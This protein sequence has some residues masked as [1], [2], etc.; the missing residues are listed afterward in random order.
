MDDAQGDLEEAITTEPTLAE[1]EQSLGFLLLRKQNLDDAETHFQQAVKLDPKDALNFYGQGLVV[2]GQSGDYGSACC[3]HCRAGKGGRAEP[4]FAEIWYNLALIYSQKDETL[5]KALAAAQHAASIAPGEFQLPVAAGVHSKRNGASGRSAQRRRPWSRDR[6]TDQGTARK[7]AEIVAKNFESHSLRLRLR[8]RQAAPQ[9]RF[10]PRLP[11]TRNHQ[12]HLRL[13]KSAIRLPKRFGSHRHRCSGAVLRIKG[14]FDGGNHHGCDLH[15]RVEIELRMKSLTILMKLHAVD[16]AKLS[17]K[18]AG[19]N[20]AAGK[21][22]LRAPACKGR[23][24]RISYNLVL[25]KPWDG[26]MQEVEF[27]N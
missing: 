16:I 23:N 22:R 1:A 2:H 26:E 4:D 6:L 5:Q 21:Y 11:R 8:S 13:A 3:G 18:S 9:N 17:V 27:R 10:R 19:A 24:V 14:I 25:D 12:P 20:A 15:Q 7:A